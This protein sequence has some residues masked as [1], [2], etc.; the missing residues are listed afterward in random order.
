MK[1]STTGTIAGRE[2]TETLG[3]VSVTVVLGFNVVRDLMSALT[4]FFG[5]R[6]GSYETRLDKGLEEAL[7]KFKE[8]AK[9]L[10]ADAIVGM[11]VTHSPVRKG[12]TMIFVYGT[13]VK[14]R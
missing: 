6:S 4:D 7:Q 2:I 10:K 1:L 14:L 13:A 5:G 12:M 8:D 11:Q 3:M 9:K